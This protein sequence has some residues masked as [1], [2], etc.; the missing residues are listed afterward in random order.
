MKHYTLGYTGYTV[1]QISALA[2]ER[3]AVVF[4]IRFRPYGRNV[5]FNKS[6]FESALQE[7]YQYIGEL[8]NVNY[9][10]EMKD[11]RFVDFETGIARIVASDKP[12]IIMCACKDYFNCHRSIVAAHLRTLGFEV[13]DIRPRPLIPPQFQL[14][15]F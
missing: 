11:T 5:A 12:V 15:N 7:R 13:E 1:A 14:F 8:G 9:K 2:K 4:D 6:R 10:L 3:D